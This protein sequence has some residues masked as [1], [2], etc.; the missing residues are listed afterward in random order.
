MDQRFAELVQQLG[1]TVGIDDLAPD[2]NGY[3]CLTFDERPVNIEERDGIIFLYAALGPLPTDDPE[4]LY[5]RLLSANC[6]YRE[7]QGATLGVDDRLG[8]LL[9]YQTPVAALEGN[10]FETILQNFINTADAW[11]GR[12]EEARSTGGAASTAAE[13]PGTGAGAVWA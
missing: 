1:K 5:R 7:T 2:D 10:Q 8:V 11:R 12:L 9:F 6:F 4:N 3:L 13:T